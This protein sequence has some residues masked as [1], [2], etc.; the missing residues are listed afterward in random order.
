MKRNLFILISALSLLCIYQYAQGQTMRTLYTS[1]AMDNWFMSFGVGNSVYY[2]EDIYYNQLVYKDII[3]PFLNL[4]G[5][6]WIT[7]SVGARMQLGFCSLGGVN[8]RDNL[9][10]KVN[11]VQERINYLD[12]NLNL[13]V[14]VLNLF[15][16][17]KERKLSFVTYAGPGTTKTINCLNFKSTFRLIFKTGGILKYKVTPA[18]S[19]FTDIQG[20][21]VPVSFQR[22]KDI[23]YD[24]Y[25]SFS[26]GVSYTFKGKKRGFIP[27]QFDLS[28][29]SAW[30]EPEP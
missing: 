30:I 23:D 3:I 2:G 4:S 18:I 11:P 22:S 28:D 25:M 15:D 20:A 8:P 29:A 16:R 17:Y 24:G 26:T 13:M 7:P 19:V 10:V 21:L 27:V 1:H 9:K 14:D 12:A 5:G 6:K